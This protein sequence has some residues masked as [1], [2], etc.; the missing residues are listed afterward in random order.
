M[1][2]ASSRATLD[3][4]FYITRYLPLLVCCFMILACSDDSENDDDRIAPPIDNTTTTT[5][6]TGG[7]GTTPIDPRVSGTCQ[8]VAERKIAGNPGLSVGQG[9]QCSSEFHVIEEIIDS[10]QISDSDQGMCCTRRCIEE[11]AESITSG[12]RSDHSCVIVGE[13]RYL[14]CWGDNSYGQLGNGCRTNSSSD[15]SYIDLNYVVSGDSS[16]CY[17]DEIVPED[18]RLKGVKQVVLGISHTCVL[19]GEG[20][21]NQILCWGENDQGQLG[22]EG[23]PS[24]KPIEVVMPK[25]RTQNED[26]TIHVKTITAGDFHTCL[27]A[28]E[29]DESAFC[30]GRNNEG[31]TGRPFKLTS[32]ENTGAPFWSV[33][34]S[35]F[36]PEPLYPVIIAATPNAYGSSNSVEC[37]STSACHSIGDIHVPVCNN[38]RNIPKCDGGGIPICNTDNDAVLCPEGND[39]YDDSE[40]D[41]LAPLSPN[42]L[43]E[44]LNRRITAEGINNCS[45]PERATNSEIRFVDCGLKSGYDPGFSITDS[46][47][48]FWENATTERTDGLPT[49]PPNFPCGDFYNA[50]HAKNPEIETE[51]NGDAIAFRNVYKKILCGLDSATEVDSTCEAELESLVKECELEKSKWADALERLYVRLNFNQD[52]E[53]SID[54]YKYLGA[55]ARHNCAINQKDEVYCFGDNSKKQLGQEKYNT[56]ECDQSEFNNLAHNDENEDKDKGKFFPYPVRVRDSEKDEEDG[57]TDIYMTSVREIAVGAHFNCARITQANSQAGSKVKCWGGIDNNNN[58]NAVNIIR[59]NPKPASETNQCYPYVQVPEAIT[60]CNGTDTPASIDVLTLLDMEDVSSIVAGRAHACAIRECSNDASEV[61]CWGDNRNRQL[62]RTGTHEESDRALPVILELGESGSNTHTPLTNVD[63][64]TLTANRDFTCFIKDGE[65]FC[66]GQYRSPLGDSV[67]EIV[68][69]EKLSLQCEARDESTSN[70]LK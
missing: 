55:G 1:N 52:D 27:L 2:K 23:G 4:F 25:A 53:E 7:G 36:I 28:E 44:R 51:D 50:D 33:E 12:V 3:C 37:S 42:N 47:K 6:T 49:V 66:W 54:T 13:E 70:F 67:S 32:D 10:A 59:G 17:D 34:T 45:L 30:W 15:E 22:R 63:G 65:V 69:P 38:E 56:D 41:L 19:I 21:S 58:N 8:E 43:A 57:D 64:S 24:L 11:G 29:G 61:L 5:T 14:Q 60:P 35:N 62:G 40:S 18:Q 68:L 48:K 31:Q 26:L 39:G 20:R 46:E 16:G 9:D